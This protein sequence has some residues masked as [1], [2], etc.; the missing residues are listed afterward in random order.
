M[1]RPF[2][3]RLAATKRRG[4]RLFFIITFSMIIIAGILLL[5]MGIFGFRAEL[6]SIGF[7]DDL[8][9]DSFSGAGV[10]I[11]YVPS[12]N[13]IRDASFEPGYE[14]VT[15]EASDFDGRNIFFDLDSVTGSKTDL[16]NLAGGDIR[17]LGSDTDGV[18]RRKFTGTVETYYPESMAE[19]RDLMTEVT[20]GVISGISEVEVYGN[21]VTVLS[22][23]GVIYADITGATP[24]RCDGDN[25]GFT[26]LASSGDICY[27][28]AADGTIY[29][30]SDGRTFV[31][32][33]KENGEISSPADCV[34]LGNKLLVLND[35][36]ELYIYNNG[37]FAVH[38]PEGTAPSCIG[39]FADSFVVANDKG[40]FYSDN[41][42]V[43]RKVSDTVVSEQDI[44]DVTAA[45][46]MLYIVLVNGNLVVCTGNEVA[47]KEAKFEGATPLVTSAVS[48]QDGK[49]VI[50]TSDRVAMSFDKAGGRYSII[51]TVDTSVDRLLAGIGDGF[52]YSSGVK[53][54]KSSVL[55]LI[56]LS[57]AVAPDTISRGDVC[58]VRIDPTLNVA[59][60][61]LEDRWVSLGDNM[62]WELYGKGTAASYIADAVSGNKSLKVTG[63]G[64]GAHVISQKLPGTSEECFIRDNFYRLRINVKSAEDINVKCWLEGEKFGRVVMSGDVPGSSPRTLSTLFA[65]T[66]SMTGDDTV[67]LYISFEG[68]GTVFI[69]DVYLGPDNIKD[70]YIPAYLSESVRN[71]A[72]SA[73]RLSGL[74]IG[75]NGYSPDI[76]YSHSQASSSHNIE[77][78]GEVMRV[79]SC[80]SLEDCLDM[81]SGSGAN[82]WIVIGS[83]ASDNDIDNFMSYMCGSASEGYGAKRVANGTAVPW[84]RR[85]DRIYIE[86]ADT[87]GAFRTDAARGGYVD[88]TI[89]LIEQSAYYPA[90]K[91]KVVFLD[92]M[93]Y[94]GGIRMSS[95]DSHSLTVNASDI[96][97][98]GNSDDSYMINVAYFFDKI[99]TEAERSK[100]ISDSGQY[101]SSMSL[102]DTSTCAEY[103]ALFLCEQA[104]F[105]EIPMMNIAIDYKPANYE[106]E[107][108]FADGK[109][110][111]NLFATM[112][113]I[114][115]VTSAS[116]AIMYVP[117]LVE[118]MDPSSKENVTDFTTKCG[119]FAFS[120]INGDKFLVIANCSSEMSQFVVSSQGSDLLNSYAIRYSAEGKL[121]SSGK[122]GRIFNRRV[123]NAGE[124]LI[125][126]VEN[127]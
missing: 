96:M 41:G 36:R 114:S 19:I 115:E 90:I 54:Y 33:T 72:P 83:C 117:E 18:M 78:D 46:D 55:S 66:D 51:S 14:Y 24:V 26:A 57:E 16:A 13:L 81:V 100:N 94:E 15:V 25:K 110:C 102:A 89:G 11:D 113:M 5:W 39:R 82:P 80:D 52:I 105:V 38:M 112:K 97:E 120:G 93:N 91:E 73:V 47:L 75:R 95:A 111:L 59:V 6:V 122:F 3:F 56:K 70:N 69:D 12:V 84:S 29:E 67:R 61:S 35:K 118:P 123:L 31:A 63:S 103:T 42:Y 106:S 37:L 34:A 76:M 17:I 124:V 27:A 86:I 98:V 9:D 88:Y 87:D 116:S 4:L 30:A 77:D 109:S 127:M 121:I 62:L 44:A 1:L 40:I 65:V 21:C 8:R 60:P 45:D 92:G 71:A 32:V 10:N 107:K 74:A 7:R 64:I 108:I 23:D 99:N 85:F 125:V 43:F 50:S 28:I 68:D 48:G 58:S 49:L 2:E 104:G 119:V 22:E 53:L 79:S 101:I 126:K 20:G